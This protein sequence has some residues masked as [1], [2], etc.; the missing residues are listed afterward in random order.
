MN[1]I[2]WP[3]CPSLCC[4]CSLF[5]FRGAQLSVLW[6]GVPDTNWIDDLGQYVEGSPRFEYLTVN[7][8]LYKLPWSVQ[9]CCDRVSPK[10]AA[11]IESKKLFS[12]HGILQLALRAT[13]PFYGAPDGYIY[14]VPENIRPYHRQQRRP[15]ER[16]LHACPQCY[17]LLD[18]LAQALLRYEARCLLLYQSPADERRQWAL[19]GVKRVGLLLDGFRRKFSCVGDLG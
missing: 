18:A 6:M 10:G 3:S 16:R 4:R 9:D 11:S 15:R 12:R 13:P 17:E 7:P 2:G 5:L 1:P 8:N 19:D 14:D